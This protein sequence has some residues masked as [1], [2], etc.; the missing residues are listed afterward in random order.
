MQL[1]QTQL[2]NLIEF[3]ASAKS[4]D[5]LKHAETVWQQ[6]KTI[7]GGNINKTNLI[8]LNQ[9]SEELLAA[10][11]A[12]VQA[13]VE[14]AQATAQAQIVDIS[15]RQRM[16]S[17][18]MAKFYLLLSWGLNDPLYKV[19]FD[20][21]K[22]E[23]STALETL[24]GSSLNTAEIKQALVVVDRQWRFFQLTR[25]MG[26]DSYLP[27]IVARTTESLLKDMNR[28]TGMYAKISAQ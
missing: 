15:G 19:E 7:A 24:N 2:N 5:A 28:I 22:L 23:F 11:Q 20:K 21:A 27:S 1:Y 13:L 12:V 26:E 17:Q 6:Y 4:Q 18:R 14:E 3:A 8:R 9:Q 16:L 25:I 10:S